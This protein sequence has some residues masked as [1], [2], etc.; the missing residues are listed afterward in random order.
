MTEGDFFTI[1][2]YQEKR[3]KIRQKALIEA[4]DQ[5]IGVE[6]RRRMG[7]TTTRENERLNEKYHLILV[8]KSRGFIDSYSITDQEIKEIKAPSPKGNDSNTFLQ[9]TLLVN[10][11][12]PDPETLSIPR[13][14]SVGAFWGP[15]GQL[16]ERL[17]NRLLTS[18]PQGKEF[19]LSPQRPYGTVADIVVMARWISSTN[20]IVSNTGEQAASAIACQLTRI[21]IKVPQSKRKIGVQVYIEAKK[22]LEDVLVAETIDQENDISVNANVDSGLF[23]LAGEAAEKGVKRVFEKLSRPG[24]TLDNLDDLPRD[25][26]NPLYR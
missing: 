14:V 4:V 5:V 17:R 8:L 1:D 10:V 9:L 26:N 11:C 18:I 7:I 12:V 22:E 21:C 3:E 24:Q 16:D 25:W 6:I 19:V 15:E 20:Q 13:I 23:M 2:D